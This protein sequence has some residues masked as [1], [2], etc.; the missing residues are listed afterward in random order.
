[1]YPF[2]DIVIGDQSRGDDNVNELPSGSFAPAMM[3]RAENL[4]AGRFVHGVESWPQDAQTVAEV[5]VDDPISTA[6]VQLG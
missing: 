1:M 5:N 2:R 6:S 3:L 4:E